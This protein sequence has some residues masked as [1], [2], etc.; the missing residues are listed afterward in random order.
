MNQWERR[1]L[2]V[3]ALGGSYLGAVLALDLF[4]S[5]AGILDRL[6]MVLFIALYCW[7]IWCGVHLLEGSRNVLRANRLFWAFQIPYLTSPVFGFYFAS[8][9]LLR[10]FYEPASTNLSAQYSIGS[11]FR[12]SLL[13]PDKPFTIGVNVFALA[14]F[15]YFTYRLRPA[16]P[17]DPISTVESMIARRSNA[18]E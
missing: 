17:D 4:F 7:G 3:L 9:A 2:G 16:K 8:G 10:V 14:I 5:A 11:E 13:Q 18:N 6:F 1:I 12:Y 15:A